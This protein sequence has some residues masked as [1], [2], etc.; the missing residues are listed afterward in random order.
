MV[1]VKFQ[2]LQG[3]AVMMKASTNRDENVPMGADVIDAN[4]KTIGTFG[5]G[6][7]AYLRLNDTKG[8]LKAVWGDAPGQSCQIN[9]QIPAPN[10][11]R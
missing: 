7:N 5:Q 6:S 1:R 4:G 11:M 10:Q 3:Y 8:T 9:Y 2:T